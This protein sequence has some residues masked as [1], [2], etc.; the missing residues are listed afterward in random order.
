MNNDMD[1]FENGLAD[2]QGL[3]VILQSRVIDSTRAADCSFIRALLKRP[4]GKELVGLFDQKYRRKGLKGI[5]DIC[6]ELDGK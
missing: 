1:N 6:A 5:S 3:T 4:D 2:I